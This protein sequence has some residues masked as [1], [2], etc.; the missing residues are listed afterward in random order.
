MEE[1]WVGGWATEMSGDDRG[2]KDGRM[3]VEH[4]LTK[5]PTI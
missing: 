3:D 2:W 1:G 5:V 4:G